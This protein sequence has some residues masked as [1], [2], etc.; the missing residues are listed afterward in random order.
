MSRPKSKVVGFVLAIV[1]IKN[2]E[3]FC[4]DVLD[5]KTD[6]LV[7]FPLDCSIRELRNFVGHVLVDLTFVGE[8]IEVRRNHPLDLRAENAEQRFR[9]ILALIVNGYEQEPPN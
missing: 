9:E 4:R 2:G 5:P 1:G 8:D 3:E 6:G 7:L